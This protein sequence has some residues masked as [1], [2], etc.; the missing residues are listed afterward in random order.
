MSKLENK[1][2]SQYVATHEEMLVALRQRAE[3]I[4]RTSGSGEAPAAE[5]LSMEAMRRTLHEL[6]VYRIELE[7]QNE[8][9]RTAQVA[10]DVE[11]TRYQDLYDLAPVGYLTVSPSGEILQSNL[12]AASLLG[13]PRSQLVNIPLRRFVAKEDRDAHYLFTQQVAHTGALDQRDVRMV[14]AAGLPFWARMVI[15]PQE[16]GEVANE[17]E[18]EGEALQRQLVIISDI[19]DRK[20]AEE[21]LY[22]SEEIHRS[23]FNSIDEGFFIIEMVFDASRKPVDFRFIAVMCSPARVQRSTKLRCV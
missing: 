21:Q 19:S 17:G 10:L 5:L 14:N 23:L 8:E 2:A 16:G 20:Q 1:P 7:M 6:Q 13:V 9:L 18:G 15:T 3:A 12:K 11:R 22:E 4:A